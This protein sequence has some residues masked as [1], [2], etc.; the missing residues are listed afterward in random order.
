MVK[1]PAASASLIRQSKTFEWRSRSKTAPQLSKFAMVGSQLGKGKGM[2]IT[3]YDVKLGKA[4]PI[5]NKVVGASQ[6]IV[7]SSKSLLLFLS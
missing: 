7:A 5:Q 4:D 1:A 3:R 6:F 2:Q